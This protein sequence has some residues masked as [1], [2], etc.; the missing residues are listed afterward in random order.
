M[1]GSDRNIFHQ[2][3]HSTN[4]CDN[5]GWVRPKSR[6]FIIVVVVVYLFIY[7]KGRIRGR[8]RQTNRDLPSTAAFPKYSK[9]PAAGP[10]QSL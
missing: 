7:V 1:S 8:D 6:A 10:V 4:G 9:Q 5:Q 2:L 3:I